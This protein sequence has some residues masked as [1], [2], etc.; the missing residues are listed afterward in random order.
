MQ[1]AQPMKKKIK[2][3]ISRGKLADMTVY[4]ADPFQLKDADELLDT[5]IEMT[6]INGDM[7]YRKE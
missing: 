5:N 3:T 1:P 2:G 4:S 7:M 6:I